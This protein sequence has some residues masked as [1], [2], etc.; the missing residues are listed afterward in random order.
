MNHDRAARAA[1]A[2]VA[3]FSVGYLLPGTLQLPVLVYDPV[4]HVFFIARTVSGMSMRYYGDLL[5]AS[6]AGIA[7]AAL[8]WTLQPRRPALSIAAATAMSLVGLDVLYYLS[9]LLVAR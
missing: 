5:V 4:R 9:R 6:A 7:A 2:G 3:A 1:L 8:W